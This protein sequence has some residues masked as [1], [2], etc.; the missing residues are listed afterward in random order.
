MLKKLFPNYFLSRSERKIF[1]AYMAKKEMID[2]FLEFLEMKTHLPVLHQ[3]KQNNIFRYQQ[4]H[5]YPYFVETGTY[6]GDMLEAQRNHFEK[7][8]SIELSEALYEKA[9]RRFK[10]YP[11]IQILLGDSG[12]VLQEVIPEI[13]EPAL[14]WL[15]G[16]YSSGIT[17]KSDKNTPIV[18][19]LKIIFRSPLKH[20]IL[21]D[22]ARLFTGKEDYPS[23]PEVCELVREYAPGRTVEVAD[24]IIRIMPGRPL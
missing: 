6:L 3:I 17:A 12:K 20:G 24:D 8:V 2:P 16:H 15:D 18:E 11:H 21:I 19:E 13:R 5:H 4:E 1:T 22:D 7:L 23:I 9:V 10:S 14:F